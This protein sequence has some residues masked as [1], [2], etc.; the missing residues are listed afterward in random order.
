MA[1][2]KYCINYIK[3]LR[4]RAK[5]LIPKMKKSEIVKHFEKEGIA[6]RTIYDTTNRLKNERSIK[7]KD[8]TCRPTS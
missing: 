3:Y 2:G 4:K 7:N 8:K 1:K 5:I 6:R